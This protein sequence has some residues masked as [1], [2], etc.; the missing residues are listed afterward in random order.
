MSRP[1]PTHCALLKDGD[2]FVVK[3]APDSI[4]LC[5]ADA[6]RQG[7]ESVALLSDEGLVHVQAD[8]DWELE[9]LTRDSSA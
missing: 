9:G 4:D 8:V 6:R 5:L 2:G 1:H 7:E 3:G